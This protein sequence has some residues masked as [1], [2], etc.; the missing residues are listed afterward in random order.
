MKNI[1]KSIFGIGICLGVVLMTVG[2]FLWLFGCAY[3]IT[4]FAGTM[5]CAGA[6]GYICCYEEGADDGKDKAR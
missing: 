5:L 2:F 4:I 6:Y 1:I 3:R